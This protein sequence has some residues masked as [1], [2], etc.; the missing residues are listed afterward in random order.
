[1]TDKYIATEIE[2]KWQARWAADHLYEVRD[3]DP[4]PKWYALT[5]FPYTSGDLHIGHWYAMAPSDVFARF[6]R[7]Q[8]FNV[9]HP[10]GFDAFG[11]PAEN[12]AIKHNIHP[13]NWTMKNV[14][15]M[16]RQL[17][18]IGAVYDW[19]REVATCLPDYY[20]W[21]QW[22]F[23]KLWQAGLAYRSKARS[24]GARCAR[25]C[26]LTSRWSTAP[27][28]AVIRRLPGATWSSCFSA[29]PATP[30]S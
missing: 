22:F 5:M 19:S 16:R 28:G 18:S 11:L 25:R 1:M 15:N 8:G 2:P 23:L 13:Y 14:E 12:A 10:M 4:R 26:W 27:A 7:M 30:T 29:S 3:D 24:T 6:K 21:T 9:L 20:R 17:K